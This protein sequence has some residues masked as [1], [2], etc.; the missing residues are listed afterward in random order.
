MRYRYL[1]A[2][3][4]VAS[5]MMAGC[6]KDNTSCLPAGV[7]ELN[8]EEH[9]LKTSVSAETV[10]WVDGDVVSING[11][12]YTVSI[13]DGKAYT[14]SAVAGA[15]QYY[16]Y[17]GC[18]TV[19]NPQTT[20]PT[21]T[22]PSRYLSSYSNGRQVIA[23]PMAAYSASDTK[24]VTF[25]HLTAALQVTVTNATGYDGLYVDSV[26]VVSVSQNLCGTVTLDLTVDD[27]GL[28]A[29]DG[30]NS[31][32]T[33]YFASE[34][35]QVDNNATL[36][37]QVPI[38][39][40]ASKADDLAVKVYTHSKANIVHGEGTVPANVDFTFSRTKAA[41]ALGRNMMSRAAVSVTN[42]T[43]YTAIVDHS[44]F[45]INASTG[46]QVSFSKGNLQLANGSTWQFAEHQYT[47]WGPTWRSDKIDNFGWEKTGNYGSSQYYKTATGTSTDVVDWGDLAI[48]NGGN[49]SN[50][51]HTM[52]NDEWT[53]LTTGRTD[54]S[55]KYGDATISG[56]KGLV[57]L[58][59]NWTLPAG[60]SF[61]T[62]THSSIY[63]TNNTYTTEEWAK[64]ES[65]G[66]VFLPV[67]Y[68]TERKDNPP[69]GAPAPST[70]AGYIVAKTGHYWTSTAR[71]ASHA[72]SARFSENGIIMN[73]FDARYCGL[74]VRLVRV[75]D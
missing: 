59:D 13:S 55:S 8:T 30:S 20:N 21:V 47:V 57:L 11:T 67:T 52:T 46:Q 14:S 60:C 48:S 66:A 2:M 45:T 65:A 58:P 5:L 43:D 17:Y 31:T 24:T 10:Q 63:Y 62:G 64:M 29:S 38:L 69:A 51:W 53:Y 73:V 49:V 42:G 12:D 70:K 56:Q 19:T 15:E 36:T 50:F 61:V 27:Y 9:G 34:S 33:V 3:A 22:I 6:E 23:L 4:A 28:A 40:I 18:G 1:F 71:D 26:Q 16:A 72:Y 39:P 54:A 41:P 32:V 37:V 68:I 35:V 7:M 74:A 25:H 44:L 75:I